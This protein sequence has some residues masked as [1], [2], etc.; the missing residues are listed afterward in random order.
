MYAHTHTHTYTL[1]VPTTNIYRVNLLICLATSSDWGRLGR[2]CNLSEGFLCVTM[3]NT[4]GASLLGAAQEARC[5][6]SLSARS[7]LFN[8]D[9]DGRD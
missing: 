3:G 7:T 2:F 6:L 4:Q 9:N 1:L 5:F 8:L